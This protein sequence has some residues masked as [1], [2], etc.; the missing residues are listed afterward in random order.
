VR[1]GPEPEDDSNE[2]PRQRP[3]GSGPSGLTLAY[4]LESLGIESVDLF[5]AQEELGGQS[6]TR[7]VDGLPVE[8]GTVYLTKGSI[9]AKRIAKEV[10]CPARLLPRAT[11]LDERGRSSIRI[12]R[13][14]A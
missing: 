9:L 14:R 8:M 12:A 5:E 6:V 11:V 10:G 3:V 1:F 2:R 7:D 13:A 4:F